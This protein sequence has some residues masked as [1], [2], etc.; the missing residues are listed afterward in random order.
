MG[1]SGFRASGGCRRCSWTAVTLLRHVGM[2]NWIYGLGLRA[3]GRVRVR[4]TSVL[5]SV[6]GR[7]TD[8]CYYFLL[9]QRRVGRNASQPSQL[10]ATFPSLRFLPRNR[11]YVSS[12]IFHSSRGESRIYLFTSL[13]AAQEEVSRTSPPTPVEARRVCEEMSFPPRH[14]F[15]ETPSLP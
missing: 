7:L 3:D 12:V 14:V 1:M 11:P 6:R 10:G 9:L 5:D 4:S 8:D 13:D 2:C 15:R